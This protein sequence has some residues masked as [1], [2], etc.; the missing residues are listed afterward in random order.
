M[1]ADS[2][3]RHWIEKARAGDADAFRKLVET[4]QRRLFAVALCLVRDREEARDLCQE[5]FLRAYRGLAGFDCDSRFFTWLYRIVYNLCI[6]A[7]RRRQRVGIVSLDAIGGEDVIE[8]ERAEDEAFRK[9][10]GQEERAR[11]LAA[12]ETL[13]PAHR[14][15]ITLREIEGLSYKEIADAVGCSI[16]TVMSRLFHARKRL[17]Q[18]L[19]PQSQPVTLAA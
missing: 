18:A 17:L 3:D 2:L 15:V 4:Y 9:I 8:D 16:G 6:D 10:D 13:S 7:H 12:M 14:A 1:G 11:I 19:Q 5:A